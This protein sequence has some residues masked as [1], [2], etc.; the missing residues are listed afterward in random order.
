MKRVI[1]SLILFLF[2]IVISQTTYSLT[3][4]LDTNNYEPTDQD[5]ILGSAVVPGMADN[6]QVT[7]GT[8]IGYRLFVE[9][10]NWRV[11][12]LNLEYTGDYAAGFRGG[13]YF[14]AIDH[15][16]ATYGGYNSVA[17]DS[18][19][20][21]QM[22][23]VDYIAT[24]NT[25]GPSRVKISFGLR[26]ASYENDLRARYD[27]GAQN[28]NQNAKNDLLGLRSGIQGRVPLAV[29]NLDFVGH[30]SVGL[31]AGDSEFNHTESLGNLQRKVTWSSTVPVF[32]AGYGLE[33]RYKFAPMVLRIWLGYDML[34]FEDIATTQSFTDST[35]LGSQVQP[36]QE[37]G[38]QGWKTGV[39]FSF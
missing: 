15:P 1:V 25:P 3:V 5:V 12:W 32:E 2:T 4:G 38:F 14:V 11:S 17:A 9:D 7:Y 13:N 16:T 27:A 33:Y 8:D 10:T 18:T 26:Y 24:L 6:D 34:R 30:F 37:A 29:P 35:S 31:L 21:L 23:D 39:S 28:V 19:I 20:E 22:I 36:G